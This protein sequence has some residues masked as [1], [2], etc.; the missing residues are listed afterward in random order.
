MAM[1]KGKK[2]IAL[3][4]PMDRGD[5]LEKETGKKK[6]KKRFAIKTNKKM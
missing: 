1:K 3:C 5:A 6:G 4:G 2:A